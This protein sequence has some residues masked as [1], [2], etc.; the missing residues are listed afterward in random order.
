MFSTSAPTTQNTSN[1]HQHES[2]GFFNINIHKTTDAANQSPYMD[3]WLLQVAVLVVTS[4]A[5]VICFPNI[6][7]EF[8]MLPF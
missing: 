8:V 3:L 4:L 1:S 7:Q 5:V 2:T 6:N